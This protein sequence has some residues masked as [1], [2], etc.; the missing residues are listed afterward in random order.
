MR[1]WFYE[2]MA[3]YTAYH[4]DTRNCATHFFGVPLIV[5]S[6]LIAFS[7]I[8]FGQIGSI[9]VT[10]AV[11][12]LAFVMLVYLVAVPMMGIVA[13]VIH[14]PMLWYA[15]SLA[16]GEAGFAWVVTGSCFV[17]G[18]VLQLIGHMFEGRRPALTD[19]ILQIFMAPGFLV[20]EGLFA[21][22]LLSNLRDNL[23]ER[24]RKFETESA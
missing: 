12:F 14:I 22:G 20:V 13:T 9:N 21:C 16:Q 23:K 24:S 17:S 5:F 19:N 10:L 4:Q 8:S 2:Q 15:E 1:S 18:W 6:I 11:V 7:F 3:M